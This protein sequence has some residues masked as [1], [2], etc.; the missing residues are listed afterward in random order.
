[1]SIR[2]GLTLIAALIVTG[3]ISVGL[4]IW[5]ARPNPNMSELEKQAIK[6]AKL[7][8]NYKWFKRFETNFLT[9]G[10][11]NRLVLRIGAL[12]IY[13]PQELRVQA[14]KIYK[15]SLYWFFGVNI[16]GIIL[17][18]DVFICLLVL[19]MAIV[20]KE[21]AMAKNIDK[22]HFQVLKAL[23]YTLS[24]MR[25]LYSKYGNIP[26]AIHECTPPP[27]LVRPIDSISELL[28]SKDSEKKLEKF[29][30]ATPFRL[31]QTLAS[32]C[33]I[34]SD[35][36]D[37]RDEVTGVYN[38]VQAMSMLSS[39]VNIE[40]RRI[41][42]Q[43]NLFGTLEFLPLATVPSMP[44]VENFFRG[45]IPG[46]SIIY[47]GSMGYVFKVLILL[48]SLLGYKV[49]ASIN[50]AVVIN[51]DDRS[52][53]IMK[54]LERKW[55]SEFIA[56]ITP[57]KVETIYKRKKKLGKCLSSKDMDHIYAEKVVYAIIAMVMCISVQYLST[58]LGRNFVYENVKEL[59]LV[60]SEE[61]TAKDVEL[62]KR[63]DKE[64]LELP[65][66]PSKSEIKTYVKSNMKLDNDFEIDNQ[67]TRLTK[68][69]TS[70]H[71][72]YFHWWYLI[73]AYL[74][75]LVA[76][77]IPEAMLWWREK[78]IQ[79]EEEE[80]VLQLQTNI[81][82]LMNTSLDT[83]DVIY[84]L[85]RQSRVYRNVL[86]ECYH[87][88][89]GNAEEALERAKQSAGKSTD[90][91]RMID[92][93]ELTVEQISLKEAFSDLIPERDHILR[94]RES[95]QEIVIRKRR[96]MASVLSLLSLRL[97]LILYVVTPIGIIGA[98]EFISAMSSVK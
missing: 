48:A 77:F 6:K 38:F 55:F 63:L 65:Q 26:D 78:I 12:S 33:Y 4:I 74:C 24:R 16:I 98:Q 2:L 3:V 45:T 9:R 40:I 88:Y 5:M 7:R 50:R 69:Y 43:R 20:S 15:E 18:Q 67:V 92:K 37:T 10:E 46:T 91:M 22:A 1:M 73:I 71:N 57:K 90:F 35:E 30:Q 93:L 64:F 66:L 58:T 34:L 51:V 56:D 39:E 60:S 53:F 70:Y 75:G 31:L 72:T 68:K 47:Q 8:K 87:N 42:L 80:D 49:I 95:Q 89:T 86:L 79:S 81:C 23:S 76:W 83:L 28:S 17:F 62:R 32:V 97:L 19:T 14:V 96:A 25:D 29:Y 27:I 59:S 36:G 54:L 52:M 44:V 85:Q 61:L 11:F 21:V 41:T 84:W 94:I 82:I 13:D